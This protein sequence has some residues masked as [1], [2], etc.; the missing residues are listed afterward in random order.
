MTSCGQSNNNL[1]LLKCSNKS[2]IKLNQSLISILSLIWIHTT[3]T[4][5]VGSTA[6]MNRRTF[7]LLRPPFLLLSWPGLIRSAASKPNVALL[8]REQNLRLR[9]RQWCPRITR[10]TDVICIYFCM[11][12][13][14]SE[15]LF[16]TFIFRKIPVPVWYAPY[17]RN[18]KSH[19]LLPEMEHY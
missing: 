2:V 10:A 9:E 5:L 13:V 16:Q 3:A 18:G 6:L 8:A 14:S 12:L 4:G 11:T 17:N 15:Q 7:F 1:S 19:T